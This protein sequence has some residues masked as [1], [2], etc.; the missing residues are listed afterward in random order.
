VKFGGAILV[1]ALALPGCG[2]KGPLIRPDAK[3]AAVPASP[4]SVP[5]GSQ[6]SEKDKEKGVGQQP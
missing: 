5:S 6:D 3:P 4:S 1:M 2:Q